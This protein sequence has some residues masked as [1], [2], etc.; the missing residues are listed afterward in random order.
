MS[1]T[2]EKSGRWYY[3]HTS[4]GGTHQRINTGATTICA[5]WLL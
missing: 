1:A 3:L 2:L 5:A 4:R